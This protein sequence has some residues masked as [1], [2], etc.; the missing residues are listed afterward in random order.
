MSLPPRRSQMQVA[1]RSLGLLCAGGLLTC[2][3]AKGHHVDPGGPS[4][5]PLFDL[6]DTLGE[7]LMHLRQVR[8]DTAGID[9]E[10]FSKGG[11]SFHSLGTAKHH[12]E[13]PAE[14]GR[15]ADFVTV[16]VPSYP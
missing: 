13:L 15:E 1:Q 4:T 9:V 12:R 7:A 10:H 8:A 5:H 2:L 6:L 3:G 11:F 16:Q 14:D